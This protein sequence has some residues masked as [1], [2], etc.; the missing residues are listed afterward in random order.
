MRDEIINNIEATYKETDLF[1][2]FQTGDLANMDALDKDS[3]AKLPTVL[4]L[5]DALYAPEFRAFSSEITGAW[6][7]VGAVR[8]SD[9]MGGWALVVGGLHGECDGWV[10]R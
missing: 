5:R 1:K 7:L 9:W 10:S 8:V 6:V 2:M 4:R 3:A